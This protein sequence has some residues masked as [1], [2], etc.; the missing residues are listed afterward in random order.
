MTVLDID[1]QV[2]GSCHLSRCLLLP[3]TNHRANSFDLIVDLLLKTLQTLVHS[4]DTSLH[5][6][7]SVVHVTSDALLQLPEV[8]ADEYLHILVGLK[9]ALILGRHDV[10]DIAQSINDLLD[11]F[12]DLFLFHCL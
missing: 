12:W 7:E 2:I 6:V 4:V 8:L 9:P 10:F 5:I 11:V 1:K 3:L